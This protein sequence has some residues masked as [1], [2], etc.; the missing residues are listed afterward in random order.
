VARGCLDWTERRPHLAGTAGAQICQRFLDR[1]WV[2]RIG[3]GRAVRVT[4][5]GVAALRD[6]L[7]IEPSRLD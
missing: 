4:P 6:L 7:D 5:A 3:T 2:T 1:R